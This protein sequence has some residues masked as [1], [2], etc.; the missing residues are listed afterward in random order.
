MKIVCDSCGAKYSIA[1]EKVAGKVFKI[2]CKKCSEVIVVRGDQNPYEDDESTRVFD[3]GGEAVWHVVVDGEQQGPFAPLQI[4][5][6]ISDGKIDW[7]AYVWK[8][9]FDGWKALREVTELSNAI[10][11]PGGAEDAAPVDANDLFAST[12]SEPEMPA[13]APAKAEPKAAAAAKPAGGDLFATSSKSSS[14]FDA[15]GDDDGL[16][17]STPSPRVSAQQAMTGQRNEN[18]VLFSLSN[19]QALATGP[20]KPASAAPAPSAPL[21][22][23]APA[24]A[25]AKPAGHA[26]GEASGL[27][28]IR[29]LASAANTVSAPKPAARAGGV[30]DLL[31]IGGASPLTSGLGAPVLA[32]AVAPEPEKKSNVGMMVGI[33]AGVL[34][35]IGVA[36]TLFIVLNREPPQPQVVERVVVQ[37]EPGATAAAPAAAG[38][39]NGT[40]AAAGGEPQAAAPAAGSTPS[41]S[42]SSSSR[43]ARETGSMTTAT[44]MTTAAATAGSSSMA[45]AAAPATAPASSTMSSGGN[46]D[47]DALLNMA[48]AM[49][50]P[51]ESAMAADSS[52]PETPSRDSVRAALSGVSGEVRACG[53]GEHGVAPVAVTFRSNG[54][55]SSANVGGQFAGTPVGSCI[56]RAVRGAH[57]PPFRNPTFNVS[58]P[59]SL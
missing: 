29:A 19:L 26:T 12:D 28:D 58:F 1:D 38:S 56:A 42:T 4:G 3:Y 55:V 8:E 37:T 44:S 34:A 25:P 59:Y 32:P 45:E 5:G 18:S 39:A 15:G 31:S 2:R 17:A 43:S 9:G 16:V 33:G 11:G 13:A 46:L 50:A 36:I 40:A 14:P 57:V 41:S 6:L 27:I 20:S 52:L 30:D 54:S 35:L 49:N 24:P 7:D 22:A 10:G 21:A 48:V 47:L 51:A 23:A 53:A